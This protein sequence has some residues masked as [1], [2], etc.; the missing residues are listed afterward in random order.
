M[1][2]FITSNDIKA[3]YESLITNISSEYARSQGLSSNEPKKLPRVVAENDY[4]LLQSHQPPLDG[5]TKALYDGLWCPFYTVQ[6]RPPEAGKISWGPITPKEVQ[7]NIK[8]VDNM[9][10]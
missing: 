8:N 5:L 2:C 7:A 3:L 4:S 10:K 6:E 1:E 9:Y